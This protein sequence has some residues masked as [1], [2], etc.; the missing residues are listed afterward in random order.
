LG[1]NLLFQIK[2]PKSFCSPPKFT[3]AVARSVTG[4]SD[5]LVQIFVLLIYSCYKS[6][7]P[8]AGSEERVIS[9]YNSQV[10]VHN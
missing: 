3:R 9:S 10:R 8:K 6:P 1:I 5:R 4:V 2:V 7:K